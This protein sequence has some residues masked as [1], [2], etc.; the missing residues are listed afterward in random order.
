MGNEQRTYF[1]DE[2]NQ[3]LRSEGVCP[4]TQGI[5]C[6]SGDHGL[7][8]WTQAESFNEEKVLVLQ[9]EKSFRD[10][11]LNNMKVLT[12]TELHT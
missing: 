2:E 4:R 11:L 3:A 6:N 8:G 1:K 5:Q 7:G 9:D 12:T 10:W